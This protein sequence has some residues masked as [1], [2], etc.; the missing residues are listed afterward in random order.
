MELFLSCNMQKI[1]HQA[2]EAEEILQQHG[3]T[4]PSLQNT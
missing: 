4:L 2:P 3:Q 1:L